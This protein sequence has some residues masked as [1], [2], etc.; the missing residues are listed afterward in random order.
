MQNLRVRLPAMA[1]EEVG[2]L[3][4]KTAKLS[5]ADVK[6]RQSSKIREIGEALI[7]AGFVSLDAQATVLG[8]PRSTA[9][10]ILSAEHKSTGISAKIIGRMLSS[11]RLPPL[12]RA[13]IIQYAEEKAAGIYGGTKTQHRRFASKLKSERIAPEIGH[14][15]AHNGRVRG[16]GRR[17]W[18]GG[19]ADV[20][21]GG[22]FVMM[23]R[24]IIIRK[25][26]HQRVHANCLGQP[27]ERFRQMASIK[28]VCPSSL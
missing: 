1:A 20:S 15:L 24:R 23:I 17:A 9:W 26:R 16:P 5:V 4:D 2:Y 8:L 19:S 14:P 13:K 7:T 28:T 18:R 3:R 21:A 27:A 10:T 12:V 22:D 6:A 25:G 11:E